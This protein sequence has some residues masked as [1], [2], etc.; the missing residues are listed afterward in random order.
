M[1]HSVVSH[2]QLHLSVAAGRQNTTYM[3]TH[4]QASPLIVNLPLTEQSRGK[5][6]LGTD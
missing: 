6:H 3:L 1:R 2:L 5:K 4:S